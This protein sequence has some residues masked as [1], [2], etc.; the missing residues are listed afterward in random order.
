M[1]Q[2][3]LPE[4]VNESNMYWPMLVQQAVKKT[5]TA[6]HAH[7]SREHALA[8]KHTNKSSL[9]VDTDHRIDISSIRHIALTKSH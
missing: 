8:P 4:L 3:N 5:T 1:S 2:W 7:P 6:S 9:E